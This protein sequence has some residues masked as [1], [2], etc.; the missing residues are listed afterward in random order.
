MEEDDS[1][2]G[3]ELFTIN[4]I[5]YPNCI[6]KEGSIRKMGVSVGPKKFIE[7]FDKTRFAPLMQPKNVLNFE[8]ATKIVVCSHFKKNGGVFED[9]EMSFSLHDFKTNLKEIHASQVTRAPNYMDIVIGGS[10]QALHSYLSGC[11][12][13]VNGEL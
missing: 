1:S 12:K 7:S 9:D 13:T 4:L 6:T 8:N 2:T 5:P 3:L 11:L 10:N